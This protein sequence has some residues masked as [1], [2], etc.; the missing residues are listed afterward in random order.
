MSIKES[1]ELLSKIK[2]DRLFLIVNKNN[3][4]KTNVKIIVNKKEYY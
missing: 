3:I 4:K 1:S 2:W